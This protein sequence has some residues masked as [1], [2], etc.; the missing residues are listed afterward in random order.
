[1]PKKT[2]QGWVA[3]KPSDCEYFVNGEQPTGVFVQHIPRGVTSLEYAGSGIVAGH[4]FK[5]PTDPA[6]LRDIAAA[7]SRVA[8]EIENGR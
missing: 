2:R 7:I 1:M 8:D 5:L 3:A 4:G 6:F